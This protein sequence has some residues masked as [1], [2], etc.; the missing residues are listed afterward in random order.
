ML[1][2]IRISLRSWRDFAHECFCFGREAV[3]TSGQAVRGLVRS[4]E[5]MWRLYRSLAHS[6]IPPATQATSGW[7]PI[8]R[9]ETNRNI[10]HWVLLQKRKFISRGTQKQN[11]TNFSYVRTFQV[12]KF[13][14]ISLG[15]SDH[16][17]TSWTVMKYRVTQKL[18]NSSVVYHKTKNP[19]GAKICMEISFQLLLYIVEVIYQEDKSFVVWIFVTSWESRQL[20]LLLFRIRHRWM[21]K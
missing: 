16:F 11:I 21:R 15:I 7:A 4:R 8:R 13:P 3:N 19:F 6:R 5:G 14:E 12:A 17:L 1:V 20:L 18:R 10:C 2:P 9:P